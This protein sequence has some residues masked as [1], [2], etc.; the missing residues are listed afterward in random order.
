[1][2]SAYDDSRRVVA[3]ALRHAGQGFREGSRPSL[4]SRWNRST[5]ATALLRAQA[6]SAA[7]LRK[8]PCARRQSRFPAHLFGNM[9]AQQWNRIYRRPAEALPRRR[10]SRS[11][12]RLLKAGQV[13]RGASMTKSAENFYT[14][15]G[16]P[17]LPQT[18]WERS[19]LTRP[20]DREV[21]CHASAWDIDD[22]ED[23]RIKMCIKPIEEDLFTVYHEL[24][25]VYYYIWYKDQPHPLPGRRA[26]RFPRSHRRCRQPVGYSGLSTQA[27]AW[28]SDG[29]CRRR[30]PSS[31]SR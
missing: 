11:A 30:K 31:I 24:G 25:H 12:D 15:I 9:W 23:V 19:M 13:G 18:F 17:A 21:M 2:S 4:L 6:S 22:K 5:R 26:R 20:R 10:A 1:M 8:R 7:A 16:F 3:L 27:S 29:Q 28:S 14:S